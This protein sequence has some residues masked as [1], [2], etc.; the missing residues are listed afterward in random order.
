MD[1]EIKELWGDALSYIRSKIEETAF[2]TWFDG[3]EISRI[4]DDAIT[5]LVPNRFHY[6]WI[7]SK[8]R[9]LLND[10][11]NK[12]YNKSLV[13]NYSIIVSNKDTNNIFRTVF[14]PYISISPSKQNN[15]ED[16]D[17]LSINN[18]EM[19]I[20]N[21]EYKK[22]LDKIKLINKHE[23]FYSGTSKQLEIAFSF[24]S[25]LKEIEN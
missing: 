7:E 4:E 5:L 16:Q 21:K 22:S 8:Y 11:I 24:N 20:K 19:L 9:N 14:S 25:L 2:Q 15:L 13:V 12:Y 23:I 17:L 10:A 1:S 6:E 18:I 3:L